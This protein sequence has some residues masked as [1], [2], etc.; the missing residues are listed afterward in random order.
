MAESFSDMPEAVASTLEI[1][2][3]CERRDQARP[4]APAALPDPGGHRAG[5]DAPRARDRGTAPPLRRPDPGRGAG[6]ARVRA[7]RDLRDGLRVL[8]PD[9]L[10][11][12]QVREGERDRGGAGPRLGRRLDRRLRPRHHRH[13]PARQRPALRALPQPGPQVDAGH[14]HRLLGARP[15]AGDPLRR[16]QVRP[17][18][19]RPDHHLRQDGAPRRH[20][21]RRA[22]P[23]LRLR[24]RR[25]PRQA[26]PRADHGPQPELRGVPEAGRGA[27]AH[28][29]LRP[30]RPPDHRHRPGPRGHRPQPLD[31]RRG[32]GDR[33]PAAPGD[34]PAA[35]RRGPRRR[36]RQRERQR[37]SAPTRRSPST[38]WARSRRSAC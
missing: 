37:A 28:L 15:R 21:G 36:Q 10:G 6:A 18:V 35:A 24:H 2:E 8:L 4:A 23:R 5:G 1:A 27:E 19:R 17:R 22:G 13:R 29:R 31:P 25:P 7:G 12:R 11:L 26:D 32:R 34:R 30:R 38:R 16:R 14:R 9:R 33:R 20:P 3:R